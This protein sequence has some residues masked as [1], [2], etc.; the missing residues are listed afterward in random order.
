M[1]HFCRRSALHLSRCP[2]FNALC[3]LSPPF[4]SLSLSSPLS[5]PFLSSQKF[6]ATFTRVTDVMSLNG[7]DDMSHT[8]MRAHTQPHTDA[9]PPP[10]MNES[11]A[12]M[13]PLNNLR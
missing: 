8:H 6:M 11:M 2:F 5:L 1:I 10:K 13:K 4:L 7:D 9:A 3:P 12:S